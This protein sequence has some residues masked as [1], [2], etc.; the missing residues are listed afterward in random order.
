M[1]WNKMLDSSVWRQKSKETR[2]VW[3][4]ML[5]MKDADGV[6]RAGLPG[7]MDR[8]RVSRAECEKALK[9][10]SDPDEDTLTQEQEGRRIERVSDGWKIINHEKYR[11]SKDMQEKWRLQKAAQRARELADDGDRSEAT[12]E[13]RKQRL[14]EKIANEEAT[15]AEVREKFNPG[16]TGQPSIREDERGLTAGEI[17]R[18]RL[19]EDPIT[20]ADE[21][22]LRA[23]NHE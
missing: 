6:V 10:L 9:E 16:A 14:K 4:T 18:K 15:E 5:L 19:K 11:T 13:A 3:V 8:A 23:K 1:M 21:A 20:Q 22:A 17:V 12:K 7:I 2:L